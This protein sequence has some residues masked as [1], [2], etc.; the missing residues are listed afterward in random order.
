MF[1]NCLQARSQDLRSYRK[2]SNILIKKNIFQNFETCL[3]KLLFFHFED[4]RSMFYLPMLKILK[5]RQSLNLA[6][7]NISKE[8]KVSI[9]S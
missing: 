8:I 7:D 4:Y 9:S 2:F 5:L 6:K 3:C 1:S